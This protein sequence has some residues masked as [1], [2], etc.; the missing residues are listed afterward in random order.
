MKILL[1]ASDIRN[2][3]GS[4][5]KKIFVEEGTIITHEARDLAAKLGITIEKR[6]GGSCQSEPAGTEPQPESGCDDSSGSGGSTL[7]QL[8]IASI[9]SQVVAALPGMQNNGVQNIRKDPV[10]EGRPGGLRLVRGDTVVQEEFN[11]GKPG[12]RVTIK[13]ILGAKDSPNMSSGFM[14]MDKSSFTWTLTYD[15]IDYVIEGTLE[16]IVDGQKYSGKAGDVFYIP[17]NSTVTFSTPDHV[18][19]FYV[20][21][22]A[23]WAEL[24]GYEK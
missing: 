1:K 16:F 3:V 6:V 24:C 20:T 9:V 11:T 4:G 5:Q 7:N 13:E 23:N 21:Y 17:N 12:D 19:F 15:E 2:L 22:P 8:D 14:T 10:I 18:K